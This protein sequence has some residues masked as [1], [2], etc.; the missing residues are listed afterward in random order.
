MRKARDNQLARSRGPQHGAGMGAVVL[1]LA[2]WLAGA[3]G[4]Q[5]QGSQD[6]MDEMSMGSRRMVGEVAPP[7][8]SRGWVNTQPLDISQLQGKVILLRFI[9]DSPSGAA[10]LNELYRRY[11]EQGLV[12][13]G[14]YAPQPM[15]SEMDLEP[16][17]RLTRALGFQFP[18]GLDSRWETTNLYWMDRADVDMS[19]VTFLIDRNGVIRYIQPDGRYEMQSQN[20]A[21]R[22]EFEKLEKEIQSLLK[23]EPKASGSPGSQVLSGAH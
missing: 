22:R 17:E 15:P 1:G 3:A 8:K 16:V 12:V 11:R 9:D 5:A 14:L 23:E 19:A 6:S 13:V 7:W 20:R 10:S 2:L 18:V 21:W 4:L